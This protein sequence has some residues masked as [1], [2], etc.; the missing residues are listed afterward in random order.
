MKNRKRSTGEIDRLPDPLKDTVEQMLLGG[1]SYREIVNYL[2]ENEVKLSQMSVCRYA[3]KYLATVEMIR[4]SQENFSMM[5]EVMA[6]YPDLDKT[7]A[8]L[9]IA[10]Q[11]VF[12]AISSMP[13]EEWEGM[14]PD[15]LLM[16][17]VY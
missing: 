6:K 17:I 11:N 15:K 1:N 14:K 13:S 8:I 9:R 10:C 16:V 4:L 2:Q 12:N 5:N 3:K 7:E